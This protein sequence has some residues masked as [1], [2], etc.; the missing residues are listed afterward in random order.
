MSSSS[1]AYHGS[2]S[3]SSASMS[4]AALH[5]SGAGSGEQLIKC[6]KLLCQLQ[7][8]QSNEM[9][10]VMRHRLEDVVVHHTAV[11]FSIAEVL[12]H[13]FRF[14]FIKQDFEDCEV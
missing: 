7:Q 2:G 5:Q 8:E 3:S 1:K 10:V 6:M 11:R 4:R 9:S 14:R 13:Q 12:Q